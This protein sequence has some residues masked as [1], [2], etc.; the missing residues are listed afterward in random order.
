MPTPVTATQ[1][2]LIN[3]ATCV[4]TAVDTLELV[5][6]TLKTPFL[7]A[8][9]STSRSILKSV[10]TVKQNKAD[11]IQLLEQTHQLLY[12]I[13]ALHL[14]SDTGGELPPIVLDH[15]GS[16]TETLVG[17]FKFFSRIFSEKCCLFFRHFSLKI[18]VK[19]LNFFHH[20]QTFFQIF[21][22]RLKKW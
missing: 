22:L 14:K 4:S 2:R 11:C 10:E 5:F 18:G 7:N 15:V 17:K 19:N 13:I 12:A 8:I 1:S 21:H 16:F 9:S 3:I 20:F 6:D